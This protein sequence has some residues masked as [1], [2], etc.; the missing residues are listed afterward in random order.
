MRVW[1]PF[2][3]AVLASS[4]ITACGPGASDVVAIRRPNQQPAASGGTPATAGPAADVQ[5][6][7]SANT[8][9]PFVDS[10]F[11]YTFQ[12]KNNGPDSAFDATIVDTLPPSVVFASIGPVNV[13]GT[14]ACTQA[15]TATSTVATCDFGTLR[16]GA[17]ATMQVSAYAPD[18]AGPFSNTAHATST[19]PDPALTNNAVTINSQA[20]AAKAAKPVPILATAFSTLPAIVSGQYVFAGGPNG[21]GFAFTP[22]TSGTWAEL[23]VSVHGGGGGR[24][25][26]WLYADDPLNP[27]HPG[28]VI[29]GPIFGPIPATFGAPTVIAL[30]ATVAPVLVAGQRYWLFGFGSVGELSGIWDLS[31]DPSLTGPCAVGP[32]GI[33]VQPGPCRYP[34]FQIVV[35]Q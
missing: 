35:S 19:V 6:T 15:L 23:A 27:G 13:S 31:S 17:T 34:A 11:T 32:F 10:L 14:P 12:I 20:Q 24:A 22:T 8:G 21:V 9:S 5:V 3:T 7:G 25:E 28:A 2:I 29:A 33:A 16:K 26:F 1:V 4:A 30:S 18:T